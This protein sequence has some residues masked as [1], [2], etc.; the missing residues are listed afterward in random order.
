MKRTR[1]RCCCYAVLATSLFVI[2]LRNPI[3]RFAVVEI[4]SRLLDRQI[5]VE[6]VRIGLS[7]FRGVGI[8][9]F[10]PGS[11]AAQ[12]EVAQVEVAATPWAGLRHG[13][14]ARRVIVDQPTLHLRFDRDGNLIT[15]FPERAESQSSAGNM[16]IGEL[17]VDHA[18]VVVH[19]A[20]RDAL[21]LKGGRL[22]ATFGT[23]IQL[24]GELPDLWGGAIQLQ[25]VLDANT[26]AGSSKLLVEHLSLNTN[27]IAKLPFVPTSINDEPVSASVSLVLSVEH[28]ACDFDLR[29]HSV[30]MSLSVHNLQSKNL[31]TLSK[32]FSLG[33]EH[34]DGHVVIKGSGDLANGVVKVA[35][36]SS[37]L[38]SPMVATASLTAE[39][40]DVKHV[41][42]WL[43]PEQDYQSNLNAQANVKVEGTA[44]TVSFASSL[45]LV[46][47]K[48]EVD[49]VEIA[50]IVSE[51]T[52][53]GG[54]AWNNLASLT[55]TVDGWMHSAGID[56]GEIAERFQLPTSHGRVSLSSDFHIPLDHVTST[57]SYQFNASISTSN[58]SVGELVLRDT[59]GKIKIENGW[60]VGDLKEAAI[61]DSQSLQV[62]TCNA[63]TRTKLANTGTVSSAVQLSVSP[64]ASLARMLGLAESHCGGAL[65][66][67]GSASCGLSQI[68][69]GDA[70]D[71]RAVLSTQ[72]LAFAGES[73]RDVDA[74]LS[75]SSGKLAVPAFPIQ[76]RRSRC[77]IA[78]A[79]SL[80]EPLQVAG[81]IVAEPVRIADVAGLINQFSPTKLP[82]T[83]LAKVEGK[84]HLA[85]DPLA[86]NASGSMMLV[87]A[88]YA[89]TAIGQAELT[90]LAD[91]EGLKLQSSSQK[92]LGGQY[93]L[94]VSARELDWTKAV[95]EGRFKNV[96]A[97][98]LAAFMGRKIALGGVLDG[99]VSV[100]SIASVD[101]LTGHAWVNSRGLSVNRIPIEIRAADISLD[102]SSIVA[103]CEGTIAEGRYRASGK[104]D[105]T[106][107][108]SFLQTPNPNISRVPAIAQVRLD[109]LPIASL[110][111]RFEIPK[112]L[113]TLGGKV[114]A[115]CVRDPAM[116]GGSALC[117]ATASMSD[118]Q[119]K[120]AR[121]SDRITS[122]I[123]ILED[124]IELRRI[125]GQFA[126]GRL[127]GRADVRLSSNPTGSFEFAATRVNLRR[128]AAAM[129]S[130]PIAGTGTVRLRGRIG[131][132]ISGRADVS[133]QHGVFEGV[134]VPDATFPIDWSFSRPSKVAR[135]QCRSGMASIGGGRVRIASEGSFGT[136]LNMT[137][138]AR[139]ERVDTAK[140][141]RGKSV[142][143]GIVNGTMTLQAK[144]ARSPKH[145]TGRYDLTMA[146]LETLEIP[147][148]DQLPNLVSLSPPRPGHGTDGGVLHGRLAGGLVH[149][150][151]LAIAQ[152]NVQVLMSG[153]ATLDGRLNF[154]VT[155]ST[156]SD[157]PADQLLSLADSPL[158]LVAPAPIALVAKA[159]DLLKDRVVHVHVGGVASR[160]T[161]RIQPGKQ[162]SQDAVRF[163]LKNSFGTAATEIATRQK[164]Q[165][166]R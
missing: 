116:L 33:A 102:S 136:S 66:A 135:W 78:V 151:E 161:M 112:E 10:E 162:L 107:L 159:N 121:L 63:T 61:F 147:L 110:A 146:N 9:V 128:A 138:S 83:G 25:T 41:G 149:V 62:A 79:G 106:Q 152:S 35:A 165:T 46:A 86:L 73:I 132:V 124:R 2:L 40:L 43:L 88:T 45:R 134:S 160:P 117:A 55:G 119:L 65:V 164:T 19:Q 104:S 50:D 32:A 26:L 145:F 53:S 30:D 58:V 84:F 75:L 140:L 163:F 81:T 3:A 49:N 16:P 133:L 126:D 77:M 8:R 72:D 139:I 122:E 69:N 12:V 34:R 15:R 56:M 6:Q 97:E 143:V 131:Q 39:H 113:Q 60:L 57:D 74:R 158:M 85:T 67:D 109:D 155:V 153:N 90:W 17:L 123:T 114:S 101:A 18:S 87:D 48:I 120:H 148:L 13:V 4:G 64:T 157:G 144:R 93:A 20:G 100:T 150:D 1:I 98:R 141:M 37:L 89:G 99:G 24:R 111:R 82:A 129:L 127:S 118:L 31:G 11:F 44:E 14:W 156:E 52:A 115:T 59:N 7:T 36:E 47:S 68:F 103:S 154:D 96:Q 94:K 91:R 22:T 70:W 42:R 130:Q 23:Q 54:L 105:L 125:D 28:P 71:V 29:R 137:T 92:F 80:R 51:V 166:R 95:V 5:E 142:G 27:Q 21:I 108:I 76:W 38:V